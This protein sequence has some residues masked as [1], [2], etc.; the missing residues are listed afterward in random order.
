MSRI[1]LGARI[2]APACLLL[3]SAGAAS[4]VPVNGPNSLHPASTVINFNNM[5]VGTVE[6]IVVGGVTITTWER[7]G[8]NA[9]R[10]VAAPL[11]HQTQYPGI[12]DGNYFAPGR[13]HVLV[14]FATPVAQAGLG[15]Y[16]PNY[17]GN[18][19]FAFDE[20]GN[21]LDFAVSAAGGT[22][23]PTGPVGGSF[24]TF[25]GFVR[26]TADI[27]RLELH[28]VFNPV[29]GKSD[30]LGIDNVMF[31]AGNGSGVVPEPGSLALLGIMSC[32]LGGFTWWRRR[33]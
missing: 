14:E 20:D 31:F 25:V 8:T 27:A 9:P 11:P 3:L 12:F 13:Q 32:V 17:D 6:P 1:K 26:P 16:D 15:I 7:E 10:T 21:L 4:A 18:Q 2:V 19:L 30:L 33:T 28:H 23:F 29:A 22:I 24:S 5:P